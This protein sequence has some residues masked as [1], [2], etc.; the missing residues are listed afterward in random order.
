M[1]SLDRF[2]AE[3]DDGLPVSL[4]KL[5]PAFASWV[6]H[7]VCRVNRLPAGRNRISAIPSLFR[8]FR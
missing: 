2:F 1:A 8:K 7:Q 3:A 4:L 6:V 5:T